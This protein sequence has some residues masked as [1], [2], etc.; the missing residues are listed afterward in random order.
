LFFFFFFFFFFLRVPYG[1]SPEGS[2][3]RGPQIKK[4]TFADA[5]STFTI[6]IA[7]DNRVRKTA[8][9]LRENIFS[10]HPSFAISLNIKDKDLILKLRSFFGCGNIKQDKCHDAIVFYVNS[11][12][13]LIEVIIPFF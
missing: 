11:I 1:Y 3:P 7:K 13:D 9:R 5:E 8:R 10:I 6:S 4:K 2:E 12:K